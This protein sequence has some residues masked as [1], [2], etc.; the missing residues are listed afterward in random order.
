MPSHTHTTQHADKSCIHFITHPSPKTLPVTP[1]CSKH[2]DIHTAA[3]RDDSSGI[4]TQVRG[5]GVFFADCVG[6]CPSQLLLPW[7]DRWTPATESSHAIERDRLEKRRKTKSYLVKP[8]GQRESSSFERFHWKKRK[9]P[10]DGA[11]LSWFSRKTFL[12]FQ[13]KNWAEAVAFT[14]TTLDL[15]DHVFPL[16]GEER[17]E[18]Q[19]SF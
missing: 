6:L 9:T 4:K 2:S 18:D 5:Y 7:R 3:L 17:K 16:L 8:R 13:C 19:I 14:F 12:F 11:A 15:A 1:S 10:I